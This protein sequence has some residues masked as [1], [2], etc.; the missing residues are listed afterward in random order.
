MRRFMHS[1]WV[2]EIP[3]LMVNVWLAGLAGGDRSR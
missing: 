2:L 3:A 1:A